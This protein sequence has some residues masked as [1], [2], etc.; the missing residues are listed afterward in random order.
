MNII[1]HYCEPLGFIKHRV[2]VIYRG[3]QCV[4]NIIRCQDE[5][6]DGVRSGRYCMDPVVAV[7]SFSFIMHSGGW[8]LIIAGSMFLT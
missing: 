7:E 6:L 4:V 8:L 3:D 2:R 5:E 1:K